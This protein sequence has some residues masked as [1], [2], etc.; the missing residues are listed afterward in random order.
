MTEWF[1]KI[2]NIPLQFGLTKINKLVSNS[3]TLIFNLVGDRLFKMDN[4]KI[5]KNNECTDDKNFFYFYPLQLKEFT[6]D[7]SLNI[8]KLISGSIDD[9]IISVPWRTMLSNQTIITIGYLKID[10]TIS[11]K[12]NVQISNVEN[13]YFYQ[14]SS[15]LHYNDLSDAYIEIYNLL[16]KYFHQIKIKITTIEINLSN[17][18]QLIIENLSYDNDI[19]TIDKISVYPV[20]NKNTILAMMENILYEKK[21]QYDVTIDNLNINL[22]LIQYLPKIYM[23]DNPGTH[24]I[25]LIINRA[26]IDLLNLIDCHLNIT[27]DHI[28]LI[29]SKKINIDQFATVK[30]QYFFT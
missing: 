10:L 27:P 16:V 21:S 25:K 1:K 22:K 3:I 15:N 13:S 19:L 29:N 4:N 28:Q 8:I 11:E 24:I 14:N 17:H 7:F 2:V 6:Q 23:E 20:D 5:I 9:L 30:V 26:K 12:I 18:L